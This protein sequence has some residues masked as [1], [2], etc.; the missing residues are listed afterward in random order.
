VER[1]VHT[2]ARLPQDDWLSRVV[3]I[4]RIVVPKSTVVCVDALDTSLDDRI[5]ACE[6]G[7][8]IY[9]N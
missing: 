4:E 7:K 1:S 6:A 9:E 5:A 3:V 8:L 2:D